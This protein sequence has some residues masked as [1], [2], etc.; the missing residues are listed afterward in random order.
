MELST[1]GT[2]IRRDNQTLETT[3]TNQTKTPRISADLIQSFEL[4]PEAVAFWESLDDRTRADYF[5][6]ARADLYDDGESVVC[7]E[8]LANA[9]ERAWDTRD[10]VVATEAALRT[11]HKAVNAAVDAL[12]A[13]DKQ[14]RAAN[15]KRRKQCFAAQTKRVNQGESGEA[16][17]SDCVWRAVKHE[18]VNTI[19]SAGSNRADSCIRAARDAGENA[20]RALRNWQTEIIDSKPDFAP[21]PAVIGFPPSPLP[22]LAAS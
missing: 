2:G 3:M 5:E 4:E 18:R 9:V 10:P 21:L 20:M 7:Q 17:V 22:P 1:A 13:A 15:D 16:T 8:V 6:S 14:F 11:A 12:W 19:L